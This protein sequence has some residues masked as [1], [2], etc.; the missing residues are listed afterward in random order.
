MAQQREHSHPAVVW[1]ARD[2]CKHYIC[3]FRSEWQ[4]HISQYNRSKPRITSS[5][6]S[7]GRETLERH[8]RT[9]GLR[10]VDA[11]R[12]QKELESV[13]HSHPMLACA[14]CSDQAQQFFCDKLAKLLDVE[15]KVTRTVPCLDVARVLGTHEGVPRVDVCCDRLQRDIPHDLRKC[16]RG[17]ELF[18]PCIHVQKHEATSPRLL[19]LGQFHLGQ[20]I[21]FRDRPVADLGQFDCK[22]QKLELEDLNPTP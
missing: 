3:G 5:Q 10:H 15:Q 16:N 12:S 11:H 8:K 19:V 13:E 14:F 18:V 17:S 2:T 20:S 1:D 9:I 22:P 21:L 7:A 4:Q 6:K